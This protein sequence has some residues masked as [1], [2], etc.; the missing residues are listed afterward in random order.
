[1]RNNSTVGFSLAEHD[2]ERIKRLAERFGKN[3]SAWL[4]HAMDLSEREEALDS[5]LRLQ[6]YGQRQAES[7]GVRYE[8]IPDLVQ[9][10]LAN[11][12]PVALAQAKL[13]CAAMDAPYISDE[14]SD[15]ELSE[16]ER[17]VR[18]RVSVHAH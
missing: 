15:G 14:D 17:L 2:L 7:L 5:L 3:R 13:I 4:R 1:M 8:D 16:A 12:D 11:P 9:E 18:E 10:A 6:A